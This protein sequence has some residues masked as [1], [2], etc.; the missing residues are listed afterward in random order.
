M[1][2]LRVLLPG[3]ALVAAATAVAYGVNALVPLLSALLLAILLG[4]VLRNAGLIPPAAER[5]VTFAAKKLLRAGV[6]LLGFQLSVPAVLELGW[7]VIAVIA[8]AVTVT[9]LGAVAAGRALGLSR[10]QSLLVA[11]GTSICGASAVAAMA[12]VLQPPAPASGG[13]RP[14]DDDARSAAVDEAAAMAVAAV[15]LF[16]TLALV[17]VPLVS[18]VLGLDARQAGVWAGSSVHEVGQVV[19][20]GGLL[21]P[22]SLDTAV[23]TKLGRVLMLAPIVVCVGLVLARGAARVS[24]GRDAAAAATAPRPPVMPLFVAGFLAAV[25]LRSVLGLPDAHPFP[26]TVKV[27][28]TLLLTAAMV[29]LGAGVDVRALV[30]RGG[31]MLLL[32]LVASALIAL[33]SL[34][35]VLLLV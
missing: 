31:P 6:V 29:G 23:V 26:A 21:G 1:S 8:L 5:G 20:A 34:G 25:V 32:S 15:T 12:A 30:R 3:L 14:E 18:G 22:A 17:A 9:F 35:A 2:H 24:G 19:A 16:G 4:V 33:V 7:G 10:D 11:T 13:G 28:A 27:L